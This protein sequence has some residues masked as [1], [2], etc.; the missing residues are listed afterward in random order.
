MYKNIYKYD[1]MKRSEHMAVRNAV[2]W[3]LWTHQL[4]EVTGND[5][6]AFLD[7][8][9]P[10]NI[11][12]LAVGRERY[13]TMLDEKGEII[14][15][16]V[17]FRIEEEKYWVSTL[18]AVY[19][20]DWF[21]DHKGGYDI[22]WTDIT[23]EW[24][25]FAVQGPKSLELL[26]KLLKDSIEGQKFFSITDNEIG[27]IPVKIN[28]AGFTGEKLGY[29]VYVAEDQA[30]EIEAALREAAPGLGG[31][32]VTEFQVMA[33][34]LPTEAGYYYMRDLRH[35]N[36]FEVGLEKNI[37]WDKDFIG[38]PALL[39]VRE[40]GPARE[41]VGFTVDDDDFYIRSRQY[42]GPGEAV[43]ID[44]EPEEIGRVY[45]LVYSYLKEANNGYIMAKK[46]VL[47]TGD[48]IKIHGHDVVITEKCWM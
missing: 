32:Q 14:D 25:M 40:E 10:N 1:D 28:K 22:D 30:D 45:K 19:M 42:G 38:K 48:R 18:F 35:A 21:Y 3:Y 11:A 41:M 26:E 20:D 36:P 24:H 9:F 17:V 34:T 5:A 44:S 37:D 39:K 43:F 7:Y 2:G 12:S 6:A 33:W 46:G 47:K 27:G 31:M 16:V 29:E 13:T 4:V 8:V 15:D 23:E